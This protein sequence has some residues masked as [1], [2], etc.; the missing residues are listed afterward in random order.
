VNE[1]NN[2]P[3]EF[4]IVCLWE[5]IGIGTRFTQWPLHITLMP[6]FTAPDVTTVKAVLTPAVSLLSPFWVEVGEQDY[7]GQRKLPVKL[8][9]H[10]AKLQA[11]HGLLLSKLEEQ[12]WPIT[13]RYTGQHFR[14]HVTRKAGIDAEGRLLIDAIYI[15]QALPQ[16]YRQIVAR[17]EFG[18]E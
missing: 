6:W 15:A 17:L 11:L 1:S 7:F 18:H 13:G 2:N 16:N 5:P 14:P 10:N 12:A 4:V 3:E 9:R 8:I